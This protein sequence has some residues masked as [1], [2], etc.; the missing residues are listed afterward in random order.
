MDLKEVRERIRE[1]ENLKLD[2]PSTENFNLYFDK[3]KEVLNGNRQVLISPFYTNSFN[4][5]RA[6]K[7]KSKFYDRICDLWYPPPEKVLP[8]RLN[9]PGQAIFYCAIDLDTAVIEVKP[10]L[11][12]IITVIQTRITIPELNCVQFVKEK[13]SDKDLDD[14][15]PV[16]REI[17]EFIHRELRRTVPDGQ[18][19]KYYATQIF[20]HATIGQS[21]FDAFAYDSVASKFKGYDLA[22]KT[23]FIDKYSEFVSARVVKVV[24]FKDRENFKFKC[25]LKS[26]KMNDLGMIDFDKFLNCE[27]HEIN[28]QNYNH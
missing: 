12:D 10:E 16:K 13:Y 1:L 27:G 18:F 6:R 25:I 26:I 20:A 7:S 28:L 9:Y 3:I 17:F 2:K 22:I 8:G 4:C 19:H 14:M 11:N 5:F 24:E 21:K 15:D 23:E